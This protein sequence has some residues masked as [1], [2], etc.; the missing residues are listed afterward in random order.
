MLHLRRIPVGKFDKQNARKRGA[1][2]GKYG[3][4]DNR[5]RC[6]ASVLAAINDDVNRNEL[7]RRDIQDQEAA[8]FIAGSSR[9]L[10]GFVV[11][12]YPAKL[13]HGFQPC[14]GTCPAKPQNVGDHIGGNVFQ[15]N[16]LIAQ[17]WKQEQKKWAEFFRHGC[18]NT[19]L[20]GDL[21]EPDPECHDAEHCNAECYGFSCAVKRRITEFCHMACQRSVNN[22]DDDH[23]GP[24]IIQHKNSF[25][26]R[27]VISVY[28]AGHGQ[29][30]GVSC[31]A[32]R[33]V[34]FKV[35]LCYHNHIHRRLSGSDY[36]R[37]MAHLKRAFRPDFPLLFY[38]SHKEDTI[39][40]KKKKQILWK[41]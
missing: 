32:N 23:K 16:I 38:Q 4:H 5:S 28:E 15:S 26:A 40:H 14:R 34:D 36:L 21:H 18:D 24:D 20:L 35:F 27:S 8:H 9:I 3:W 31:G 19:S 25:P 30:T 12:L 41:L 13:L 6:Y 11:P 2:R 37:A 39:C 1:G 17:S 29:N 10:T 33:I 7:Q 22:A